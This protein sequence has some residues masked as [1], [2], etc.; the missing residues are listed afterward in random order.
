MHGIFLCSI[1]RSGSTW[2]AKELSRAL[3]C[4]N[5]GENRYFWDRAFRIK[6][7]VERNQFIEKFIRKKTEGRMRFLDKSTN[8]YHYLESFE[9]FDFSYRVVFLVRSY[10]SIGE[11]KG[12]LAKM[13]FAPDRIAMRLSKYWRDYGIMMI[14]PVVQRWRFL[15]L[16]F[17]YDAGKA[18]NTRKPWGHTEGLATEDLAFDRALV[19]MGD[20]VVVDYD[21]FDDTVCRLVEVGVSAEAIALI[22]SNFKSPPKSSKGL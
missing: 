15:L 19:A 17:G 8:L 1:G 7:R 21:R 13:V 3:D 2:F 4:C 16:P 18:I 9:D 22:R 11:S 5:I 6:D 14:V 12:R 10:E 20:A